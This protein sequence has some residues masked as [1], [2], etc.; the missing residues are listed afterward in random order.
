LTFQTIQKRLALC[1]IAL[2]AES[3]RSTQSGIAAKTTTKSH[4]TQVTASAEQLKISIEQ[5]VG[6]GSD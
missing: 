3:C 5:N 6:S 2:A 1:H 4:S